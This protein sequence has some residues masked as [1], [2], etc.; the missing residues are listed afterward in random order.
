MREGGK[1]KVV[2]KSPTFQR[3]RVLFRAPVRPS[4]PPPTM[5]GGSHVLRADGLPAH[6]DLASRER[7]PAPGGGD[8]AGHGRVR[9]PDPARRPTDGRDG[10]RN[11]RV[12]GQ[13]GNRARRRDRQ[14]DQ[15]GG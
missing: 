13:T 10:R 1:S 7:S 15:G 12:P 9:R 6:R 11:E 4:I 5:K 8:G 3:F 14:Q 2:T